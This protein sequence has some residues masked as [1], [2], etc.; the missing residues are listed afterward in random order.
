MQL[1]KIDHTVLFVRDLASAK[2]YYSRTLGA[3]VSYREGAEDSLV[4]EAGEVRFFIVQKETIPVQQHLSF[5]V[6]SLDEVQAFLE[7]ERISYKKGSVDFLCRDNY[8]WIEW[9][10]P[11]EIRLEAVVYSDN[12]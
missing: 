3:K 2:A 8:H 10:D 11:D 4:V 7:Q 5:L 9:N 12:T 6:D 1:Q